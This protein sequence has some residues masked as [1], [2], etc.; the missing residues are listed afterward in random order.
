MIIVGRGYGGVGEGG[1][2]ECISPIAQLNAQHSQS[3]LVISSHIAAGV[4][5]QSAAAM[6]V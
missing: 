3:H 5:V 2:G 1:E 4:V 6:N